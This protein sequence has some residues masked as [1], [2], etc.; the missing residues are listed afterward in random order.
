[1]NNHN[2]PGK[3]H[4]HLAIAKTEDST[5]EEF[6]DREQ[7]MATLADNYSSDLREQTFEPRMIQVMMSKG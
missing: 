4:I 6:E 5:E 1:V 3:S 2:R 7:Q